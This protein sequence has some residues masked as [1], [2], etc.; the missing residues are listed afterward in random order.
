MPYTSLFEITTDLQLYMSFRLGTSKTANLFP[1][2]TKG[3]FTWFVDNWKTLYPR[4][5]NST[6][7]DQNLESALVDFDRS[8][9]SYTLGSNLNAFDNN[10]RFVRFLPFISQIAL[11][12]LLLENEEI[13]YINTEISRVA[14]F[15]VAEFQSMIKFLRQESAV[16]S[17]LIGK[18]DPDS[19]PK[20][21]GVQPAAKQ[22]N[23]TFDDLLQLE[24]I[25]KLRQVIEGIVFDL[26]QKTNLPPNLLQAANNNLD[27]AGPVKVNTAYLSY[28]SEPFSIS[29]EDMAQRFLGD[30][31]RWYELITVNNL[32]PPFIDEVG[33]K[34]E[35]LTPG[36]KNTVTISD[37]RSVDI[38]VAQKVRVGSL[39]FREETRVIERKI[40]NGDGTVTLF[41][42]GLQNLTELKPK[43]KAYVRV[44]K[45]HTVNTGSFILIPL[46]I[47]SP[48]ARVQTPSSDE[49]RRLDGALLGFG[50]DIKRNVSNNDIVT[51]AS[52]NF[53][54]SAGVDNVYQTIYYAIRTR[55]GELPF[56]PTT[57]GINFQIGDRFFGTVN[58]AAIFSESLVNSLLRD[59]RFLKINVN[60][61]KSSGT[62]ISI[63]MTV[64]IAGTDVP[65]PLSFVA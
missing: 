43:D 19:L 26:R 1:A 12:E 48:L 62:S 18:G 63:E 25:D 41:L 49:L 17:S 51:D 46:D 53:Q 32:Q 9:M 14:K 38:P 57:Y 61:L 35:L 34:F 60:S 7:G 16:A 44:F 27:P 50:I 58:E 54:Y 22:R 40:E 42:S 31:T 64:Y 2:V 37:A 8:I 65:I 3:R 36:G 33:Q 21:F 45:P 10:E 6:G 56:H 30:K 29:L 55:L 47:R 5:K 24:R 59:P 28:R 39:V 4:F 20:L 23:A 52:G 11:T 13:N 15:T